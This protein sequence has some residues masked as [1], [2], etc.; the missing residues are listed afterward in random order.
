MTEIAH[1]IFEPPSEYQIVRRRWVTASGLRKLLASLEGADEPYSTLYVKP[2][3]QNPGPDAG[4]DLA[5]ILR[6]V[7]AS[8]TGLAIFQGQD[9]AIAISP[10][11]PV[12]KDSIHENLDSSPLKEILDRDLVIGVVLLRLGNYAIGVIHGEKRIASKSGSR[13]VKN[14]H[15]QGGSSQRRFERSRKRLIREIYD[16]ACEVMRT[17]FE[18][19]EKRLD[20]IMLGGEKTTLKGLLERCEYLT[21]TNVEVMDR[22]LAV[23]RPGKI[24]LDEIHHEV[25]KSH[26][27]VLEKVPPSP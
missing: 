7:P 2:D 26:V 9:S 10:P 15:K 23:E 19:Y 22:R 16:K 6:E 27:Y 13:H 5:E 17:I 4:P 8:E 24:A 20:Y 11:F 14:R 1:H 21:K 25:W 12:D 3:S 18:P